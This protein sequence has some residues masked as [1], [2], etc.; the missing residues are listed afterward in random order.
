VNRKR[1]G[2]V[3]TEYLGRVFESIMKGRG[4]QILPNTELIQTHVMEDFIIGA[5]TRGVKHK[6]AVVDQVKTFK[7]QEWLGQIATDPFHGLVICTGAAPEVVNALDKNMH[8]QLLPGLGNIVLGPKDVVP[9]GES[10]IGVVLEEYHMYL[11][12]TQDGRLAVGGG[13]WIVPQGL[14]AEFMVRSLP[15]KQ[16]VHTVGEIWGN[17]GDNYMR[18]SN[19]GK[20]LVNQSGTLKLGGARP[21]SYFGNFPIIKKH[22]YAPLVINT[23][24]AVN[25]FSISWKSG[26][27]A[28]DLVLG[29]HVDK[30]QTGEPWDLAWSWVDPN[31]SSEAT[32]KVPIRITAQDQKLYKSK[33]AEKSEIVVV[34]PQNATLAGYK[35]DDDWL[36]VLKG[37]NFGY[38]K[39]HDA[40]KK[41]SWEWAVWTTKHEATIYLAQ[42]KSEKQ[43]W[44]A[45]M[46]FLGSKTSDNRVE[47]WKDEWLQELYGYVSMDDVKPCND[48]SACLQWFLD[49]RH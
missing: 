41:P 10:R 29:Q 48:N 28:A 37:V 45:G 31:P 1:S 12:S 9:P 13:L 47:I 46:N 35:E 17:T 4:H 3:R 5:E 22:P 43:T 40:N 36:L 33:K 23:G 20:W 34:L 6:W 44:S 8:K 15:Y 39:A 42:P 27:I 11:R 32:F 30:H 25:G 26:Q 16:L 21:L 49:S 7:G 2:Y 14:M 19:V 18:Q 38:I 24:G